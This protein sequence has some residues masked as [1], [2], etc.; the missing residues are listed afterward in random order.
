MP[1]PGGKAAPTSKVLVGAVF[2]SP[3]VAS[4]A[5]RRGHGAALEMHFAVFV[6]CLGSST[7][8]SIQGN[9]LRFSSFFLRPKGEAEEFNLPRADWPE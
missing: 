9:I 2:L 5:G 8:N 6:A 1:L 4:P 7:L 3:A